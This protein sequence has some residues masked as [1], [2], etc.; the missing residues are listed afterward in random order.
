MPYMG[1][2]S[3]GGEWVAPPSGR[4]PVEVK[5]VQLYELDL[6]KVADFEDGYNQEVDGWP[7]PMMK[8]DDPNRA[9]AYQLFFGVYGDVEQQVLADH[10]ENASVSWASTFKVISRPCNVSLNKF[11]VTWERYM[12]PIFG[13]MG[14]GRLRQHVRQL[15]YD[16]DPAFFAQLFVGARCFAEIV[17]REGESQ[18]FYNI[19]YDGGAPHL[20]PDDSQADYNLQLIQGRLQ[21]PAQASTE[22]I[23]EK[24]HQTLMGVST[25]L[26]AAGQKNPEAI[27]A[28]CY[29]ISGGRVTDVDKLSE[30]EG[31]MLAETYLGL[32]NMFEKEQA[33]PAATQ[34]QRDK[35]DKLFRE[36][37]EQEKVTLEMVVAKAKDILGEDAEARKDVANGSYMMALTS[38]EAEKM[39]KWL[40]QQIS[41]PF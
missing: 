16:P 22:G 2:R 29:Q 39:L 33:E 1:G 24:T 34:E 21:A 38:G 40:Q 19:E 5:K 18:T 37:V 9:H 30:A 32:W 26:Q 7:P 36:L 31:K 27:K 23:T 3:G 14:D 35:I 28:D 25:A 6:S 8:C 13:G 12:A 11:Y 15:G 17:A 20:Y 41:V 10:P 4:Q